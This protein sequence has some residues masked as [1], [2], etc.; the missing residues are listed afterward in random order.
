MHMQEH[1][2]APAF[3][4]EPKDDRAL[5]D[6]TQS[7]ASS[8]GWSSFSVEA[9][10]NR[11]TARAAARAAHVRD[12]LGRRTLDVFGPDAMYTQVMGPIMRV[13]VH[14]GCNDASLF[15]RPRRRQYPTVQMLE[16]I[17]TA[18]GI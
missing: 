14:G 4:T 10:M 15:M 11:T 2:E 7:A 17:Q 12:P 8:E 6:P 9:D 18:R 1:L 16:A 3:S 5:R 13:V